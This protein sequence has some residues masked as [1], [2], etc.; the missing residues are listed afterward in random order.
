MM[1]LDDSREYNAMQ[2]GFSSLLGS[3]GAGM[4]VVGGAAKGA[5]GLADTGIALECRRPAP[6]TT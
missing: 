3:I 1:Q 4:Q 6:S 5:S 2:T